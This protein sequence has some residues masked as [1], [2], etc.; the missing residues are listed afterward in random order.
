MANAADQDGNRSHGE[1][2]GMIKASMI[3]RC[4]R[5]YLIS[6]KPCSLGGRSN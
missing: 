3:Y 4:A 5:A 6:T 1:P 2:L